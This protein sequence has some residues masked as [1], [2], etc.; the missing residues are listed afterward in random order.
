[1]KLS[2]PKTR[3]M[4]IKSPPQVFLEFVRN[5]ADPTDIKN[6]IETEFLK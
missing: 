2:I 4:E 3:G 6:N 5:A 1:M